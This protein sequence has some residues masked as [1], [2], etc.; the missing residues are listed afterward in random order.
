MPV[1]IARVGRRLYLVDRDGVFLDD[2]TPRFAALALPII[3]GLRGRGGA[4]AEIDRRRAALAARLI[5]QVS[6]HEDL[7]GR[8]SQIDVRDPEDAV[9]LL[10]GD[11]ARLRRSSVRNSSPSG[12]VPIS[13]WLPRCG[14]TSRGSMRS[15]SGSVRAST[16]VLRVTVGSNG[17]AVHRDGAAGAARRP[18]SPNGGKCGA[19]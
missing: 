11:P 13:T 14:L 3:D 1:G 8:L 5:A 16:S 6:R 9:V 10:S 15:I 2:Y 18:G 12:S 19:H 4:S 17:D 7:A